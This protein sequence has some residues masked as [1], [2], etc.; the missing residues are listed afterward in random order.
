MTRMTQ[1]KTKS[2]KCK[3]EREEIVMF[4]VVKRG[5]ER[6]QKCKYWF[7]LGKWICHLWCQMEKKSS[8]IGALNLFIYFTISLNVETIKNRWDFYSG[9]SLWKSPSHSFCF[10]TGLSRKQGHQLGEEV[11]KIWRRYEIVL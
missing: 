10:L 7:Y 2:W 9:R 8:I 1:Y 5:W 11:F 6:I 3:Q 4:L